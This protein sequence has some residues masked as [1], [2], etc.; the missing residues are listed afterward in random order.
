[1]SNIYKVSC[2][3]NYSTVLIYWRFSKGI[4]ILQCI[5][6]QNKRQIKYYKWSTRVIKHYSVHFN[7]IVS[8]LRWIYEVEICLYS[9]AKVGDIN[10]SFGY[11]GYVISDS[12]KYSGFGYPDIR[13][14]VENTNKGD[15]RQKL[16][17]SYFMT[18]VWPIRRGRG[19]KL[20]SYLDSPHMLSQY[21]LIHSEAIKATIK[22]I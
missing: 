12:G 15:I 10:S 18:P 1:M 2:T 3:R 22:E 16:K 14:P 20:T 19:V 21:L 13:I 4:G 9:S 17:I 5:N 6:N 8:F 11:S 7:W